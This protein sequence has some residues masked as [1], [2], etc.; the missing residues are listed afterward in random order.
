[1]ATS[2]SSSK[3]ESTLV[4]ITDENGR[5]HYT[6]RGSDTHTRMAKAK[7]KVEDFDDAPAGKADEAKTDAAP[8]AG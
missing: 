1:V 2:K 6:A 8:A 5:V 3:S 7:A 4:K